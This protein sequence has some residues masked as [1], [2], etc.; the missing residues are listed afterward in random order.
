MRKAIVPCLGVSI[1]LAFSQHLV[2]QPQILPRSKPGEVRFTSP[3][4]S[5][6]FKYP[7]SLVR[8]RRD[9][10]E[11]EYW[12][13]K[14][15]SDYIPVCSN[16]SGPEKPANTIACVAYPAD[17]M[18]GTN[19]EAAAFSVNRLNANDGRACRNV[20]GAIGRTRAQ[21][22]NGVTF[23]VANTDGVGLGHRMTGVAYR[24]F[25]RN[26]CYELDIRIASTN[27]AGFEGT[28]REFS[29]DPVY[30]S[31]ESVLKT[32]QFLR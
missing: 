6:T 8:C 19:F 25:H 13:P 16:S 10:K 2:S 11:P 22:I 21:K 24:S 27:A 7:D 3:D 15:C 30:R 28:V 14:S 20:A 5:F 12:M 18:K 1:L 4:R 17:T 32:F 29:Y 9:P 31:L 23:T 26:T